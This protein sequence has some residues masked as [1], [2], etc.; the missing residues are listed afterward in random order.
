MP[1][2]K[3]SFLTSREELFVIIMFIGGRAFYSYYTSRSFV[4]DLC[5]YGEW[6]GGGSCIRMRFSQLESL[7]EQKNN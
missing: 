6:G 4:Q 5:V 7:T 3:G 2:P 1:F